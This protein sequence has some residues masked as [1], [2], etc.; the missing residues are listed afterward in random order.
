MTEEERGVTAWLRS[1]EADDWREERIFNNVNTQFWISFKTE[2]GLD[3]PKN[4]C[5]L[6]RSGKTEANLQI[7]NAS[8]YA[9][10]ISEEE[11]ENARKL[12]CP[13]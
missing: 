13:A 2:Y 1:E 8:I 9:Y 6:C 5:R 12:S 10:K 3:C 7:Q 4:T 11:I